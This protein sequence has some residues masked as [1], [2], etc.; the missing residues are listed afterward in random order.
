[1]SGGSPEAGWRISPFVGG[2]TPELEKGRLELA[3]EREWL[4]RGEPAQ[5][6]AVA[7]VLPGM[8]KVLEEGLLLLSFGNAVGLFELPFIGKVEVV[9]GKWDRSHYDRML[10]DLTRVAANLPFS[11]GDTAALPYDRSVVAR[12][13][14]VYHVFAYLRYV[15][16]DSP[17][18]ERRL[19]T[20]LHLILR[21]PHSRWE[22][23]DRIVPLDQVQRVSA[24]TL[25][26]LSSPGQAGSELM[27]TA[28]ISS[29][30]LERLGRHV[31]S[32]LPDLRVE[33]TLDTPENRFCKTFLDQCR[34]VL[35]HIRRIGMIRF[36]AFGARVAEEARELDLKLAPVR[37]HPL[38]GKVGP[39][40]HLP[41]GSTVLQQRRGY[42]Q[43]LEHFSRLRLATKVPLDAA[44]ARD[45][46]E[47]KDIALLYE[48]W[49]F[50][51]VVEALGEFLG[52]PSDACRFRTTGFE[53][54]VPWDLKL[55]WGE[56][57]HLTYS[58][59]F[60]R[61]APEDRRS[62]S[63]RLR[64]DIALEVRREQSLALHLLDAKFKLEQLNPNAADEDGALETLDLAER[65]GGY[66]R[67]D[68]YKMHTYRDAI[69]RARTA[70]ILY[71]GSE[72]RFFDEIE[73]TVSVPGG[74]GEEAT[75]VGGIPLL[76]GG[77]HDVLRESLKALVGKEPIE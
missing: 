22:R 54:Q 47:G 30:V 59:R 17:P 23:V 5:I 20:A 40:T 11:A 18:H 71:P 4:L 76:P 72:F 48:I 28:G 7:R 42:C 63:V 25:H 73:G 66:T 21:D 68:L 50:F 35:Q 41:T 3:G 58:P 67:V 8:H 6:Q 24:A 75:G 36:D 16:S 55:S 56:A 51:A 15:L 44:K 43:V 37:N 34:G 14:V 10:S 62:Y 31:P 12:E 77:S 1:M 65:R 9:S 53:T 27:D 52:S 49:A 60:F 38:W 64:P 74:L 46:L 39:M 45:L 2:P 26:A 70:W 33:L 61:S 29:P 57:V 13:D 32:Q 69:P 19:L